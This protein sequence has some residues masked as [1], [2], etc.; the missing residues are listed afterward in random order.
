[1][2]EMMLKAAA[3]AILA[4]TSTGC[5]AFIGGGYP[6]GF[7]YDGSTK[8]HPMDQM[9]VQGPGKSDDKVGEACST[10]FVGLVSM[11][12]ASLAAAKKAGGITDVHTVDLRTFSILG[13][14]VQGCTVVHGK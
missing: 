7:A 14:Y 1:M 2:K 8:P 13:V 11:G 3:C 9:Q 10:G 4:T 12:D 5:G 6:V